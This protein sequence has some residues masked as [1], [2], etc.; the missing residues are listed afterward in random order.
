MKI[1]IQQTN[2]SGTYENTVY[3]LN[4]KK[5]IRKEIKSLVNDINDFKYDPNL[6][7]NQ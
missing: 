3:D 2:G 1:E 4:N 5:L 7:L 6:F